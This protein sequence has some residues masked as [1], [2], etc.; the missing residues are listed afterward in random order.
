[1]KVILLGTHF[2]HRLHLVFEWFVKIY[3]L[4]S[5]PYQ[6]NID[7]LLL[8]NPRP[9]PLVGCWKEKSMF[10]VWREIVD[11]HVRQATA[12]QENRLVYFNRLRE[13][14]CLFLLL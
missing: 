13:E 2:L 8:G 3:R 9:V 12:Q 4:K 11:L 7:E 1:M 14:K 5:R 6:Q 10:C